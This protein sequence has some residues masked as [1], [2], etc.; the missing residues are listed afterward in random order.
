LRRAPGF[1]SIILATLALGIGANTA[2]FS[3]VNAVLLRP[4][5]YR[6]A[7]R[8]ALIYTDDVRRGLHEEAT[9]YRTIVD[10]QTST[11]A[12][13]D[14][15]FYSSQRVAS[16]ANDPARSRERTRSA[17]VS[18]N[19]FSVLGV[20]PLLG[21][22]LTPADLENREPVVVISFSYWQRRFSGDPSVVGKTITTEDPS[23]GGTGSMTV[24][25]VMPPSF[26]FPDKQTELWSPAT[27]YWRFSRESV[28]RFPDWA[29]R[30]T[31]VARL[32]PSTTLDNAR[33]DLARVG[34]QLASDYPSTVPDFPGF[35]TSVVPMLDHIAGPG[36]QSALYV[37]LGAVGL[38]LLVACVNVANLLLARG[39]TRQR[40]F[41]VR[42][43]LGAQ[44]A[45]LTR[46][47]VVESLLLS[48]SGGVLGVALAELGTRLVVVAAS[49]YLPR[50][51]EIGI[52]QRV[53]V[54]AIVASVVSG[55]VF[56]LVPA[57]RMSAAEP[58]DALRD[59]AHATGSTRLRRIRGVLV[60]AECSLAIVL[61]AGA[62]LLLRSLDRLRSIDPGFDPLGVL[63]VRI[64]L[65][66]EPPP[67]AEERLQTSEIAPARAR[68]RELALQALIDR[69][70]ALPGVE[71]VGFMDDLFIAGQGNK[72]I[73]IPGQTA[74]S[75]GAGE[76]NEG[77][78]TPGYFS[79]MRVRLIR[80]RLLTRD[81]GAQKI[82]A[83]WSPVVT[84]MSLAEKEAR[85]IA[86]PVVVNEAFAKRFFPN[87]D[88]VGKRFCVDPT[89]KTYWYTIVGVVGDMHRS[90]L[91]RRAIPEY[92]GPYLPS[93]N[94]RADLLVRVNGDPL[95]L[96]P[97]VRREVARAIPSVIIA[98]VSTADALLGDF[99]A[100]RRLQT[101]LLTAFASLA[102]ILAAIG[103]Y[104]LVHYSV[105]ERTQE[106]G[107]RV[108]LGATAA[109]VIAL[110]IGQGMRLPIIGIAIGL[111]AALML[112]RVMSH[113]LFGVGATDPVTFAA[114]GLLLAIVAATACYIPARR[115]AVIDPVQALKQG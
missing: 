88:P 82:R 40:E 23:K 58:G 114:V 94:G 76:L 50:A 25:G 1:T 27:T 73:A 65:P 93:P 17:L 29:R 2:M 106:I 31:A 71:S 92:Y 104:G 6:D 61:L 86:E 4:L 91:E 44:R 103:V 77:Y 22:V 96:A 32:A 10:W 107:V 102:L 90:G 74:D 35:A 101:W 78:A 14:I 83:L 7:N 69:V 24:V 67:T 21:R 57:I 30:W 19:F 45:R 46:Q 13:S 95:R 52:D 66:S 56:G 63:T 85:A 64:E 60:T 47:L 48:V 98:S 41:A 97:A 28:E 55:L 81:D 89:N 8:L 68:A 16:V 53:L 49:N 37:L 9:A 70:S 112:T 12:F 110:V 72:S 62:G 15:A 26:Y 79:A 43:A 87:E 111:A 100:Q 105:S 80:G 54:F 42:R 75:V 115:A 51:D 38:V 39:A 20:A 18:S 11:H 108:A 59:G 84:S 109:D 3:V 33:N 113:L 5:P 36:L 99:G 34:K